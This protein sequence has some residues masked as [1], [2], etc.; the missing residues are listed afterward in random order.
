VEIYGLINE[1][2]AAGMAVVVVSSEM[3][4]VIGLCDRVAVMSH[5]S[6]TGTLQ[7]SEITEENIMRLA[8]QRPVAGTARGA[9]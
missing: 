7:G 3:M 8:I 5:G 2:A 6:L 9:S 4:E 1:L